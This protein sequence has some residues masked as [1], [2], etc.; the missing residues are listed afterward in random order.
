M[1]CFV[2]NTRGAVDSCAICH[3][4]LCEV[5]SAACA[6]CGKLVCPQ[7]VHKTHSGKDLCLSC[8]EKRRA[9]HQA[10]L[11]KEERGE[12]PPDI[13]SASEPGK[14]R[15]ADAE[16]PVLVASARKPPPPWTLCLYTACLGLALALLL[17]ALPGMRRVNLPWGGYLPI[18]YVL[19]LIPA[20]SVFWGAGGLLVKEYR[21]DRMRCVLGMGLALVASMILVA[22]VFTDPVRRAEA[23][24]RRM[25]SMRS[26]MSPEE[27]KVWR[28]EKLQK[29]KR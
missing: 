29:Y 18:P 21:E 5:C 1:D 23:E 3:A 7:H 2:C 20:V 28:E 25:E 11:A 12:F 8:Q 15:E 27:L 24:A 26:Q 4:M 9:A 6:M 17:L 19:L 13:D 22:A 14:E 16:R 10:R